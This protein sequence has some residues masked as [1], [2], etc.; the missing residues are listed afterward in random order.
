MN[1]P[2]VR[3][4]IIEYLQ[5]ELIGPS[6]GF[7]AM[8]LNKEEILRSQDPPRLRYSSGI[9]FPTRADV[10]NQL[11]LEEADVLTAEAG[12]TD[13]PEEP[14][15]LSSGSEVVDSANPVD[16]QPETDVDLNLANQYLPSAMGASALVSVPNRLLVKIEAAQYAK[17]DLPGFGKPKAKA[18]ENASSWAWLR[19]PISQEV[20]L[21]RSELSPDSVVYLEKPIPIQNGSKLALH[22]VSR[23]YRQ[24]NHS[25]ARLI[26]FTLINR[27]QTLSRS[28][29][30]F[31]FF[32]CRF[33][34]RAEDG[35]DC[36]L[37]YPDLRICE[38]AE[39][40]FLRLLYRKKRVFAVGHGCSCDW[41]G[42]SDARCRRI[43]T[44]CLPLYELRPIEHVELAGL[45]LS[46]QRLANTDEEA[47]SLCDSLGAAYRRW[48]DDQRRRLNNPTDIPPD[49]V[50]TAERNLRQ[51]EDCLVRITAGIKLLRSDSRVRT[52]FGLANEAM[53]KQQAH[54]EL[55]SS[56]VRQWVS[57]NG[58]LQVSDRY[59]PPDYSH[60]SAAWRPFQ[61]AFILMN[62]ESITRPESVERDI[63]DLI[64]FPTGGGKTEAYLG[65]S[66]LTIFF[67]RLTNRED[68][69]TTVLMRYTLRLLTTQQFQRAASLICACEQ[70]RRSRRDTLGNAPIS[71]GLWVGGGVSPNDHSDAVAALNRLYQSPNENKFIV[72][73]CPWCGAAMGPV[74]DG[75]AWKVRG[76]IKVSKPSRVIYKCEDSDCPFSSDPGLPLAVVDEAIYNDPPT[77]LIGTVDKFAMLPWRPKARSLFGLDHG[78]SPP[79][80]II[81]DELHLISGP[82]GSMVAHYETAIE[83]LCRATTMN[84]GPKII[85]STATI[86]RANEQ[87]AALYNGRKGFLF[88][89]Q[90]LEVG[91]SFFGRENSDAQ[92]RCYLGVF[93]SALPSH[94]TAQIRVL[95]VL[96]QSVKSLGVTEA[97]SIDP[98]W[99]LMVYFNSI[100]EL[101]HAATLIRADIREYMNA[102]WDRQ[103]LTK[104]VGPEMTKQRRFINR[105]LELTSR[106]QSNRIPEILAELFNSLKPDQDYG[107]VDVCL[108]TNMIQVGLDVPRLSLM[109][110]VGQPKTT[111]EYIQASSRV[112]RRVPGLVVTIYNPA[113][114]RD[115]SHYEH[116]RA[117]HQSIYQY[118][119][120][121]SIT[122]FARPVI[123]RALHAVAIALIRMLGGEALYE[124][125][126][127]P[128]PDDA[129]VERVKSIILDRVTNVD[130]PEREAAIKRLDQIVQEWR[131]VPPSKYGGFDPPDIEEPLMYPSGTERNP[132][133][134]IRPLATPSSMRN[135]D[136]TCDAAVAFS[137]PEPD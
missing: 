10:S 25:N 37:E 131:R 63:V 109:A 21:E 136:A 110:V 56:K 127:A 115:R 52:A 45:S 58:K 88:P 111:S 2:E 18:T 93:A 77:M 100:R 47:L 97:A 95:S 101:G 122:P 60:R 51:C 107:A 32:Q 65:L 28:N 72:L 78:F 94:V 81:Q 76:Y 82:L 102:M 128:P 24:Q 5:R 103:G 20:V 15:V 16:Q 75:N 123:E 34:V 119:E 53:Y 86:S 23:P 3:Q 49:L 80:L 137:F 74:K 22:L 90:G 112:G 117:Y 42:D 104:D 124:R 29:D 38:E 55:A 134:S 43:W 1:T 26:T 36:F 133:W 67:R 31:C 129:I 48:I 40:R 68:A 87:I 61:L 19:R 59:S 132:R 121:T 9:L 54:Y 41:D 17:C 92:G 85:A 57:K 27:N 91:D 30:E 11:D 46:M 12:P 79:D 14:P 135:V 125:P 39:D 108:A 114:P 50:E 118:V 126:N 8:Q 130:E 73:A 69:G 13:E 84:H 35:S 83:A 6:P 99:T 98:F 71:I 116:F 89:P 106:I 105:D 70:I 33:E 7:P 4:K 44:E 120:P 113:R 66:A 62:L 64:W 96:L